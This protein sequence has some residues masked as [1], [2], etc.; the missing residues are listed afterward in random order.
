MSDSNISGVFLL[1]DV[2]QRILAGFWPDDFIP[3]TDPNFG[4]WAGGVNYTG[5]PFYAT[6]DRLD[7]NNDLSTAVFRVNITSSHSHGSA[8]DNTYA[9]FGGGIGPAGL[10]SSVQRITFSD[11]T[12]AR[13]NRG[14]LTV[15]RDSQSVQDENY[16]WFLG[17]SPLIS[18]TE[19][20]IFSNDTATASVR[21]TLNVASRIRNATTN[22]IYGWITGGLQASPPGSS[23]VERITFS[24]DTSLSSIRGPLNSSRFKSGGTGNENYGWF[25]GGGAPSYTST[26]ERIDYSEDTSTSSIR[27][28]LSYSIGDVS[29]SSTGNKSYGWWGAGRPPLPSTNS[30]QTSR[31]QYS[32]DTNT[33]STRGNL[34][35]AALNRGSVSGRI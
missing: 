25:G 31:K 13:L 6:V 20:I 12:A 7:F 10:I 16:A 9:W 35:R 11:D 15:G 3:N 26:V 27:G 17:G 30:S 2:R 32:N 5:T 22:K 14:P 1:R 23:L 19:R 24:N 33:G 4:W 34:S 28:P 18:T 21:G 29:S 8:K